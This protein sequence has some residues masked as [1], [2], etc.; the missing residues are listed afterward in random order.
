MRIGIL[1][2]S[3]RLS[4]WRKAVFKRLLDSTEAQ[5]AL[6]IL[7]SETDVGA[8][9]GVISRK[10][11]EIANFAERKLAQRLLHR[12]LARVRGFAA[13]TLNGEE[14]DFSARLQ[15]VRGAE[16]DETEIIAGAKLDAV[17]DLSRMPAGVDASLTKLGVWRLAPRRTPQDRSAPLGFWELYRGEPLVE[18]AVLR[19]DADGSESEVASACHCNFMW[20]WSMNDL[21]LGMKGA[22]LLE[23]AM[24]SGEGG[25]SPREAEP[26]LANAGHAPVFFARNYARLAVDATERALSEDRWRI[27]LSRGDGQASTI[28]EPP[29]HSYWADPFITVRGDQHHI[30]FE[31]YFF[32]TRRGVISHVCVENPK[33]GETLRELKSTVIID[34]PHH[35]SYPFLFDHKGEL[36]MIPESS[37]ART[38]EVWRATDFPLGWTRETTL[39]SGVS[40]ADSSLLQWDGRWWLFTNIDRS[41]TNDHRSE[42][43]IFFADDPLA[44]PWTPHPRNP[45]VVDARCGRMAGG[46]LKAEDGR[47]IRCGQVQGRKY[48]QEV[49]YRLITELTESAYSEAPIEGVAPIIVSKGARTHHVVSR[50][51]MVVA[52]ECFMGLKRF[53]WAKR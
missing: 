27:L 29:S 42:L 25:S 4:G 16:S 28:I 8:P 7:Q 12:P 36:F 33:P 52:D 35:L 19:R 44:G 17:I 50:D 24:K 53:A 43:H 14:F 5:I 21:L 26:T 31:E 10:V 38:V 41:G 9:V 46:F 3:L 15:D 39:L 34:E 48:G 11:W 23:T 1:V 40:A 22:S 6:V 47:P 49:S 30:F 2:D 45:V 20:S 51:G 32:D 18:L 13:A 37:A